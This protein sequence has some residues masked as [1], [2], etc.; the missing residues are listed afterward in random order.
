MIDSNNVWPVIE[1][2]MPIIYENSHKKKK[3]KKKW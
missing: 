1:T 3:I 2:F